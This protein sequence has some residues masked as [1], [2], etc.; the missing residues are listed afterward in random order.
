MAA[1]LSFTL[2][3]V[4]EEEGAAGVDG[5]VGDVVVD[6]T[7]TA[8]TTLAGVEGAGAATTGACATT[9]VLFMTALAGGGGVL[10]LLTTPSCF[11][12]TTTGNGTAAT[13]DG[14]TA[15]L[16]TEGIMFYIKDKL[17]LFTYCIA[18]NFCFL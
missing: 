4:V 10:A 11:Y 6:A 2:R 3:L 16:C 7:L 13:A 9:G 12:T 1:I 14:A 17:P 18:I 8:F 15:V 5:S